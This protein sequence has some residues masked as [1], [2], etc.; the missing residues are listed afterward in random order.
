MTRAEAEKWLKGPCPGGPGHEQDGSDG[1]RWARHDCYACVLDALASP[2]EA[3]P[4]PPLREV[5]AANVCTTCHKRVKALFLDCCVVCAREVGIVGARGIEEIVRPVPAPPAPAPTT[6]RC[7][8]C[9]D[10][11]CDGPCGCA[12][13]GGT[14]VA[15]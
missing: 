9:E 11:A 15:P 14:G 1:C 3:P 10:A 8:E 13:C 2:E 6:P 7:P 4:D 5:A 12:V